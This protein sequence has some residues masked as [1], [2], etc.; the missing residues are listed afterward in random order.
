MVGS[1]SFAVAD[2]HCRLT[3]FR[4][5]RHCGDQEGLRQHSSEES[6][7]GNNDKCGIFDYLHMRWERK[8]KEEALLAV[9]LIRP[10]DE[11]EDLVTASEIMLE[12]RRAT[13][14]VL[15]EDLAPLLWSILAGAHIALGLRCRR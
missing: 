4:G 10:K 8:V 13:L 2:R 3:A 1:V 15:P 12:Q 11:R 5:P 6:E 14:A 7:Q 9:A